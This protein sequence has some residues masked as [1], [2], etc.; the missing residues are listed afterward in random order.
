MI[1]TD[2][3]LPH[4]ALRIEG[5]GRIQPSTSWRLCSAISENRSIFGRFFSYTTLPLPVA[6]ADTPLRRHADSIVAF[7]CG[8]AALSL[9]VRFFSN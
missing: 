7:G 9:G 5:F 2:F 6:F 8:S 4:Q 3:F 1:G